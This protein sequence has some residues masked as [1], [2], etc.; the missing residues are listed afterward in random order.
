MTC[1]ECGKEMESGWLYS[2]GNLL[3]SP[4]QGKATLW[5]GRED[6]SLTSVT[7][8]LAGNVPVGHFCKDCRKV[9]L[10]Y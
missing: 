9:I 8:D 10:K 6:V 7:D 4:K 1:P 2:R 5:K 3:W